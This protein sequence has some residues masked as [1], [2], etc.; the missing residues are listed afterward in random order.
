[1]DEI[2]KFLKDAGTYYLATVDEV[3]D[4][5]VRPFGTIAKFEDR[6]YFQTGNVKEVFKQI[7]NH[8]RIAISATAKDG[9]SWIRLQADAIR[10]DRNEARAAVLDEY[11]HLKSMYAAD[12]GNCEVLY[13]ENITAAICSFT[14]EPRILEL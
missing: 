13:L 4:P 3:G 7:E 11:P 6:L 2:L 14:A 10:D 1:M 5:Q 8:P 9:S 12:D